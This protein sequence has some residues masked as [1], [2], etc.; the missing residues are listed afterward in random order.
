MPS[1]FGWIDQSEHQRRKM[2][3]VLDLF[4]QKETRDELGVSAIRDGFADL[5]FPGTGSLQ[6]RVRYFLFVPW[7]Y[8]ALEERRV[9]SADIARRAR[10]VEV[11]LIEA[12]LKSENNDGT[13]GRVSRAALHRFPSNIYWYGLGVLG[14]RLFSGSQDQ[15]HRRLDAF[16]SG[17]QSAVRTDDGETMHT[18]R[19]NWHPGLPD[20][21]TNFPS[22]AS[23]RL[24]R[25]EAEY[26]RERIMTQAPRSLLAFLVDRGSVADVAFPWSHPQFSEFSLLIRSQLTH[27]QNFSDTFHGAP[28]LYNLMLAE[29]SGRS[30]L[31]DT[32]RGDL[33]TWG[34]D[35]ADRG[36]QLQQWDLR[37]FWHVAGS[38]GARI[39]GRTRK[40]VEE[41]IA[42]VLKAGD[43]AQIADSKMARQ[44]IHERERV[45]KSS[46]ARLDNARARELWT[47][48]AG[49]GRLTYRWRNA[50]TIVADIR[51]TPGENTHA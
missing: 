18:V 10:T 7:M 34:T 48:A 8:E 16:Y 12:L 40:F 19:R 43:V 11:G 28:L 50:M 26:L 37:E 27:A 5:L 20:P 6:T 21:P 9:S 15:Y 32:Y 22:E 31:I 17:R 4:R 2:L 23:F 36:P 30:D 24:E 46:L 35:I 14:I 39:T 44:L 41:W 13:I 3:D 38:G 1:W 49:T 29:M 25:A 47:G 42:L 51:E 33:A 45:L